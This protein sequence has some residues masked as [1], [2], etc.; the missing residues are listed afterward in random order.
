FV[1]QAHLHEVMAAVYPDERRLEMAFADLDRN[2]FPLFQAAGSVT[3]LLPAVSAALRPVLDARWRRN[4]V[5]GVPVDDAKTPAWL[6]A[7]FALMAHLDQVHPKLKAQGEI[8]ARDIRKLK[9]VFG[10]A[11]GEC[12]NDAFLVLADANLT[13]EREGHLVLNS[14]LVREGCTRSARDWCWLRTSRTLLYSFP[15]T[16]EFCL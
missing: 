14:N 6:F 5:S 15:G 1:N 16:L 7:T 4:N 9:E 8:Y 10:G 2:G 11:S 3:G 12:L 13:C